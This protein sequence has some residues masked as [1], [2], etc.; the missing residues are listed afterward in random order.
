MGKSSGIN[1]SQGSSHLKPIIP[2][3][4]YD[5]VAAHRGTAK[6]MLHASMLFMSL[7]MQRRMEN[8]IH[9]YTLPPFF[10]CLSGFSGYKSTVGRMV[11]FGE[12]KHGVWKLSGVHLVPTDAEQEALLPLRLCASFSGNG[13]AK[14]NS[15]S[16]RKSVRKDGRLLKHVLAHREAAPQTTLNPF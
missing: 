7:Y 12:N 4:A 3:E 14:E 13:G 15:S 11:L 16:S 9:A 1:G 2:L 6:W 5:S 8:Y 10:P